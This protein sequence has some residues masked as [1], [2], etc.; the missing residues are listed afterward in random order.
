MNIMHANAVVGQSG[1]PTSAINATLSGVIKGVLEAKEA[2]YIDTLYGMRNGIEGFLNENLIDLT[3]RFAGGADLDILEQTPAAAL[4]SCRKKMKSPEVEP[5]TYEKLLEIFKKFLPFDFEIL[6]LAW[7]GEIN[8]GGIRAD[9]DFLTDLHRNGAPSGRKR[10]KFQGNLAYIVDV[11]I[12]FNIK[13]A[14]SR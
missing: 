6:R 14:K 4:G 9:A 2:G 1:G 12:K 13:R 11:F 7:L 8:G 3:E 10:L 5:E